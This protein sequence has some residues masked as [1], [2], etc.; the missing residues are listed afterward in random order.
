MIIKH[1]LPCSSRIAI[2]LFPVSQAVGPDIGHWLGS[3]A[4]YPP[5]EEEGL[6]P[7]GRALSQCWMKRCLASLAIF[8]TDLNL[9]ARILSLSSLFS[10][11]PPP[12]DGIVASV[13]MSWLAPLACFRAAPTCNDGQSIVEGLA[14]RTY[15]PPP[16]PSASV[17]PSSFFRATTP[18]LANP[19]RSNKV[20][21]M[22]TLKKKGSCYTRSHVILRH[23]RPTS[24]LHTFQARCLRR[25]HTL[26]PSLSLSLSLSHSVTHTHTH[27]HTHNTLPISHG[28]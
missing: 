26:S 7:S 24:T 4:T 12:G 3:V 8:A 15:S 9:R 14:I 10:C 6:S 22:F 1:L 2:I 13:L 16:F 28:A 25:I 17:Y 21:Y 27:T 18:R 23:R 5:S 20:Y 11:L 19:T